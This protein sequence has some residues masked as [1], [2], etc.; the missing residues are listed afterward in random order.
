MVILW[1][2]YSLSS[3]NILHKESNAEQA[4]AKDPTCSQSAVVKQEEVGIIKKVLCKFVTHT[5]K[6]VKNSVLK[7]S[8]QNPDGKI[9]S[10]SRYFH[11]LENVQ[12]A[13]KLIS[14]LF[15]Y[16]FTPKKPKEE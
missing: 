4:I 1:L 6:H 8:S 7:V 13:L 9:V 10:H 15:Y 2:E 5:F 14:I 11:L 12:K 16:S 3:M